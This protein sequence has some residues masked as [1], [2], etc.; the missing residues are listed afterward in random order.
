ME[1]REGGPE[2][3]GEGQEGG[4]KGRAREDGARA[5]SQFSDE[6]KRETAALDPTSTATQ[7]RERPSVE[8]RLA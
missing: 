3:R 8:S 2:G 7:R 1:A 6:T 4:G 5:Q